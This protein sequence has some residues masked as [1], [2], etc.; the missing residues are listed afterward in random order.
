MDEV[1]THCEEFEHNAFRLQRLWNPFIDFI[2]QANLSLMKKIYVKYCDHTNALKNRKNWNLA[3]YYKFLRD[4]EIINV[5]ISEREPAL[6]FNLAM[7]T[8]VDEL[9]SDRQN[10][11]QFVEFLDVFARL[12]DRLTPTEDNPM[13]E[14]YEKIAELMRI[15]AEKCLGMSSYHVILPPYSLRDKVIDLS[16]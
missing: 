11:M 12:A 15:A 3:D 10:H 13:D 4:L 6:T 1:I 7:M 8:Q 5:Y 2:Y 9:S 16:Y 14:L